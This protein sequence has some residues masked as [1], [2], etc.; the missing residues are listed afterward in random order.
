MSRIDD[1]KVGDFVTITRDI[2]A[3]T[4]APESFLIN[5]QYTGTPYEIRSFGL[6][7][8]LLQDSSGEKTTLDVRRYD[9]QKVPLDYFQSFIPEG[10]KY[11]TKK[12]KIVRSRV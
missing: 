2:W 4:K 6:P 9:V 12:G 1:L 8:I 3:E 10:G 11:S 7:F 5:I